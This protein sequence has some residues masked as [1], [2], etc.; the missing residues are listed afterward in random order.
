MRLMSPSP[1][2][3]EHIAR[4]KP[5][6][7]GLPISALAQRLAVPEDTIA[8]LASNENPMG[9]SPRALEALRTAS[10]D[11]SRYP[12]NDMGTLTAALSAFH[13]LSAD[14]F[15]LGAGSEAVIS[16]AAST[17][18]EKGSHAAYSQFS[19]QTFGNAVQRCG[20]IAHVVPSP[21]HLV[22]LDGLV[23]TL[24]HRPAMVYIANPGNPTGTSLEPAAL[25]RFI[26]S[27]PGDTV[28]LLD[29]AYHEFL[30]QRLRA[31]STAWVRRFPNLLVTRTFSKA[32]GLAGLRV[33]YG[34]AQPTLADMLR[35]V[36][37]PFTVTEPAQLAAAAAL[38]D[39]EFLERTIANNDASREIL[40]DGLRELG[41]P[42]LESHTNF[43][44]AQVGDGAAWGRRM[45]QQGIIVRPV[46]GYGL[47][48]WIRISVGTQAEMRRLLEA[49]R[50]S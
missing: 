23:R 3:P 10:L 11:L 28:V 1:R 41:I 49:V 43:V 6:V 2:F 50:R 19:F 44:L 5:Y 9:P 21:R 47:P 8:K 26:E 42:C 35:R 7:P 46:T 30:P 32:Y 27:V 13:G 37:A 12:D 25:L 4:L 15:V 16:N 22:D 39:L 36:R 40:C 17:L 33:G 29:E 31:D 34:I 14:W 38:A 24:E 45:E 48:E 20:A 18:L